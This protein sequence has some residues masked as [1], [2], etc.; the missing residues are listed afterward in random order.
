MRKIAN[1]DLTRL[2]PVDERT[3]AVAA[4]DCQVLNAFIMLPHDA[5]RQEVQKLMERLFERETRVLHWATNYFEDG[6]S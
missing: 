1:T 4:K 3:R 2:P 6:D 5:D